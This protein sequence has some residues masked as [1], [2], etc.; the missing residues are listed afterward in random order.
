MYDAFDTEDPVMEKDGD[1][2][3]ILRS[4]RGTLL[5]SLEFEA[6]GLAKESENPKARP[7]PRKVAVRGTPGGAPGPFRPC[8]KGPGVAPGKTGD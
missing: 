7:L 6:Q 8:P 2:E 1:S 4:D 3:L 5:S